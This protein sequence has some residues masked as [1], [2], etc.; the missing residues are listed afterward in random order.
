MVGAI[1]IK[2]NLIVLNEI[3]NELSRVQVLNKFLIDR[4][5]LGLPIINLS[6]LI[7]NCLC[8]VL[9]ILLGLCDF[10]LRSSSLRAD[11][12]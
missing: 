6:L 5:I 8:S 12:A 1:T 11:L 9:L 10:S 2:V 7:K 3:L 4:V